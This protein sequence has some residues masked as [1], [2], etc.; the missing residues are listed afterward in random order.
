MA[1]GN[2]FSL[3]D[4][5]TSLLS[6]LDG[7]EKEIRSKGVNYIL[8]VDHGEWLAHFQE[9][10]RMVPLEI[11]EHGISIKYKGRITYMHRGQEQPPQYEFKVHVPFLGQSWLFHLRP[12]IYSL[13][14][15]YAEI[16]ST[17]VNGELIYT[18]A[19]QNEDASAVKNSKDE[20]IRFVNL[21]IPNINSDVDWY[22][23]WI[24]RPC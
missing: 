24:F 9:K 7:M 6:Y 22:H 18:I 17:G 21:N 23:K 5:R 20:F 12:S 1:G 15:M 3:Q 14:S 4:A 2:L 8:S 16:M 19:L 13:K 11:I 10:H